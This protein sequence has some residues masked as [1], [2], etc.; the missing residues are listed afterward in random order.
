MSLLLG[1]DI[2]ILKARALV[3]AKIIEDD[4]DHHDQYE[5]VVEHPQRV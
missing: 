2:S 3:S 5:R 4:D 1:K